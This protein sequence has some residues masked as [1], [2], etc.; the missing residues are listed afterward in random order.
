MQLLT[1]L[2]QPESLDNVADL[3]DALARTNETLTVTARELF[4]THGCFVKTSAI[5]AQLAA[6]RH[7]DNT[8][9]IFE[10]LDDLLKQ[11]LDSNTDSS[12]LH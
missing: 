8:D 2:I 5:L 10:V 11:H 9:G 12:P 1:Q 7:H 3:R 4:A 6:H